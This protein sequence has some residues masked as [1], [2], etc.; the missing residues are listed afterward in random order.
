M[1][2]GNASVWYDSEGDMIEVLWSFVE[3]VYTPTDDDRILKHL[4]NDGN[5][6][7]FIIHDFSSF[8]GSAPVEFELGAEEV[9]EDVANVTAAMAARDLDISPQKMRR[10]IRDGRVAGAQKVDGTWL[11]PTPIDVLPGKRGPVG[12]A[13]ARV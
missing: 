4:D 5:V 9:S 3:R 1:N 8:K 2:L 10:L 6:T 12:A 13:G 11:I 7:G